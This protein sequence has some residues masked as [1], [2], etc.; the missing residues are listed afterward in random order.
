MPSGYQISPECSGLGAQIEQ[1]V[2]EVPDV[3]GEGGLVERPGG[4]AGHA[5]AQ[6][7]DHRPTQEQG[8]E[9][10]ETKG[11]PRTLQAAPTVRVVCHGRIVP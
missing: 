7:G 1:G 6:D 11:G 5:A 3:P 8:K 4:R 10:V 9:G 2:L